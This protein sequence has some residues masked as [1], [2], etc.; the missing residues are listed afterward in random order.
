MKRITTIALAIV[1][2]LFV[3]CEKDESTGLEGEWIV[4]RD[5][6]HPLTITFQGSD[7]DYHV[8]GI[9]PQRDKGTFSYDGEYLTLSPKEFYQAEEREGDLK[10]VSG[11]DVSF[12]RHK[13]QVL[14]FDGN[15]LVAK[16]LVN[17]FYNEGMITYWTRGAD[18]Q[19]L[20]DLHCPRHSYAL[21]WENDEL[22]VVGG[23]TTG[24]VPLKSPGSL[25]LLGKP[26]NFVYL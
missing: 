25:L 21:F 17:D 19:S 24:F 10:K 23:H 7:Y 2:A 1:A 13:Y 9:A 5:E 11:S 26:D 20:E 15:V 4:Y 22:V 6:Y 12:S 18:N 14:A 3:S 8:K 16:S